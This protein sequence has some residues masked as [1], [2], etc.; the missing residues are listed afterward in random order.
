MTR[1][2]VSTVSIASSWHIF[3]IRKTVLTSN[4]LALTM[5][6][7]ITEPI[8]LPEIGQTASSLLLVDLLSILDNA[9]QAKMGAAEYE[10][11]KKTKNRLEMLN[12]SGN[13]IDLDRMLEINRRRNEIAHTVDAEATVDELDAAARLIRQQLVSW[14]FV[15][16]EEKPYELIL[17]QSAMRGSERDGVSTERDLIA[18]VK[19]EERVVWEARSLVAYHISE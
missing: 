4:R 14:G 12:K 9:M 5:G 13:L 10:R 18:Q 17:I 7:M 6:G 11:G 2:E 8:R 16:E 1:Y 15:T 3:M 19:Q